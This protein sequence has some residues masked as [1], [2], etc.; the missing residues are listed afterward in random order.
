[1]YWVEFFG[2]T[3]ANMDGLFTF[4]AM[5]ACAELARAGESLSGEDANVSESA[6]NDSSN[7]VHNRPD[8]SSSL[9]DTLVKLYK[10]H[11]NSDYHRRSLTNCVTSVAKVKNF[12][13]FLYA[14]CAFTPAIICV[15]NF[16][17]TG[18]TTA[19]YPVTLPLVDPETAFGFIANVPF[20]LAINIVGFVGF[21]ANDC[22]A[23]M[24]IAQEMVFVDA[25]KFNLEE[26]SK[27]LKATNV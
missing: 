15:I 5:L 12:I 25:F 3:S 1:M 7:F 20:H 21:A 24:F 23:L 8:P 26:L 4:L 2:D 6:G 16:I 9:H 19:P 11:E 27:D 14:N 22:M 10:S 17:V 18:G 13:I